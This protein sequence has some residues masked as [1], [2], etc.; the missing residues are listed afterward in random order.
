MKTFDSLR[1]ALAI[2]VVAAIGGVAGARGS[3]LDAWRDAIAKV[4]DAHA[5]KPGDADE[6]ALARKLPK[7]AKAALERL[8]AGAKVDAQDLI[9]AGESAL[10]LDLVAEFESVRKRLLERAPGRADELGIVVSRPRFQL[11]GVDGV[12]PSAATAIADAL[13]LVL[14]AYRDVFHVTAWSKV[15]GKKLRVRVH[16]VPQIDDPPHFAPQFRWHSEIDFPVA[17]KDAF[18]SPTPEGQFLFYGLCHELGHVR[19]MWGGVKD[20]QD[21]HAW[22]HYTGVVVVEHLATTKKD[23]GALRELR[24][25]KWRTLT[26]E[27]AALAEKKVAP[28]LGDRQAVLALLTA[29]HDEVGPAALGDALDA[30]DA[31]GDVQ[32]VNHVRY[33]ALRDLESAL[34]AGPAGRGRSKAIAALFGAR[35]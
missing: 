8:L 13:E 9:A 4:N 7:P 3:D 15:P 18:R 35:R 12:E 32:R 17:S 27:R 31:A 10:D 1:R 29:L 21:H 28:G 16:L 11:R 34:I 26:L 6:A 33:Y 14:D 24:D 5:A 19:A 2:A 22:A 20:E 30:L 23:A 25:A